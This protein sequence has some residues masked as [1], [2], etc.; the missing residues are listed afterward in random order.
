MAGYIGTTPVPQATQHRESFTA[1]GG[2]TSFATAG[3]TPQFIDVYLNGVK[4]APADYTATNGSD[5]VLASGA[6]ASDILEIVAYTPFEIANQTFTGTTTAANLTVTG[7]FTSQGIDDNA[8]ATAITIDSSENVGI[9]NTSPSSYNAG[10]KTLVIG[11]GGTEGI[12][13]HAGTG[14]LHFTNGADTTERVSIKSTVASNTLEFTTGGAERLRITSAGNVGIGTTSPNSALELE[15]TGNE[16]N[17]TLDNTTSTTG[18]SYSIRSGNTGNLDLYDNDATT[19]RLVID[20]SGNVGIATSSPSSYYAN[21]L[22]VD[23]GSSAQS[24]I[25][26]VSDT[27]NQGMF[28]FADGT[29]GDQRYRGA[30]D[31][32]HS[33]DSMAF[34]AA[35]SEAM[36]IDSSGDLLVGKTVTGVA[37]AGHALMSSGQQRATVNGDITSIYN[38]LT[39]DGDIVQFRKDGS[40]VGSIGALSSRLYAGTGDTGLFFN[41]QTDQIQPWNTSTNAARDAAI[42]L[43][44]DNRRFKDLYLSGGVYLGGT[45][46]ANKLDDYEEGSYTVGF[47]DSDSGGNSSSTTTTGTYTKIG[48]V[49]TIQFNVNNLSSSGLTGS[50]SIYFDLPFAVDQEYGVGSVLPDTFN[51]STGRTGMVSR[52][53]STSSSRGLFRAYGDNVTDVAVVWNGVNDGVTDFFV[54]LS[55]V[56]TT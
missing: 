41:D 33:N 43:G 13:I 21:H 44:D 40:T 34:L 22:V 4:L 1:T 7:A 47:H 17:I 27:G 54:S 55:Y 36:R 50:S 14:M 37:T 23:T 5:V 26:I 46:A 53:S 6:T 29:S 38:R 35:G 28:A 2:Q 39:S 30:I 16:T 10:S 12:S 32:N 15:G 8:D 31:Y 25:T 45:V 9:G 49:V 48:R 56:T 18:R 24:G 11:D 51:I 3:Y 52:T 19:A 20:S 42:D